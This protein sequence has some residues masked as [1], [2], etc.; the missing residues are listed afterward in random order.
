LIKAPLMGTK[1]KKLISIASPELCRELPRL[2]PGLL[3]LAGDLSQELMQALHLKNGFYAF[4][5]ALHFFPT[6]CSETC[7]EL[8]SWNREDSWRKGY[9]DMALG[10]LFFAED[11]FGVQFAI[12]N[13]GG[14]HKFDPETGKAEDFAATIDEWATRILED[15]EYETGYPLARQWQALHGPLPHGERL[16]PK[17]P[18]VLGGEYKVENLYAAPALKGMEFRADMWRQIRDLPDGSEIKINIVR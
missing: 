17:I 11:I 8:E 1:L 15:Y 14:V 3:T 2:T 12:S 6:G 4:E 9:E 5:S 13:R 10:Y 18:F 7:I 16:L